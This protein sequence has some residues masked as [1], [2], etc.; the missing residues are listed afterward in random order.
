MSTR[1]LTLALTAAMF[2]MVAAP[3]PAQAGCTD[4]SGLCLEPV[5]GGKWEPDASLSAKQAKAKRKGAAGK[6]SV[7]IEDG[8]GSVFI[9]G[10]FAGTAPVTD[11]TLGPGKHDLQVRDGEK[12]LAE[13]VVTIPKGATVRATVRHP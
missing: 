8:R 11:L 5:K 1:T 4:L 7:K 9:D 2:T 6:L 3:S 12:I 13:G 10:R